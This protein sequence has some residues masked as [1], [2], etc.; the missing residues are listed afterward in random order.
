MWII[1]ILALFIFLGCGVLVAI[2]IGYVT[3]HIVLSIV[4]FV[5]IILAAGVVHSLMSKE[6]R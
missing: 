2:C 3:G 6:S 1:A 4:V 5:M